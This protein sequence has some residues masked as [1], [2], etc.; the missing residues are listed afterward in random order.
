MVPRNH[1]RV[2]ISPQILLGEVLQGFPLN[3]KISWA[4]WA[5]VEAAYCP[6]DSTC[7]TWMYSEHVWSKLPLLLG[8][9]HLR[10]SIPESLGLIPSLRDLMLRGNSLEG[11]VPSAVLKSS[12]D[13]P[14][15]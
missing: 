11:T 9:N 1:L 13:L 6:F 8:F 15:R 10:G 4:P 5:L 3:L 12:V 14:V 7:G 2:P